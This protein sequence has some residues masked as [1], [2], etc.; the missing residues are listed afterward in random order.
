[1]RFVDASVFVHG[2]I[3]PT[4]TLTAREIE[5]KDNAAKIIRRI[6]AGERIGITTAQIS[7]IANLLETHSPDKAS[8]VKEFLI[9]SPSVKIYSV[10][11]IILENAHSTSLKYSANKIGLNDSI[12]Y[13]TM[14]NNGYKEIYSFDKDFDTLS[15]IERIDK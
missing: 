6:N 11:R 3:N 8:S 13:V 4:R 15:G 5:M 14:I 2:I 7:E 9:K 10:T 1:M 12:A